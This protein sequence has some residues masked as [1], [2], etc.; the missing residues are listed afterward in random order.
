MTAELSAG[1]IFARLQQLVQG[2]SAAMLAKLP[3]L[4]DAQTQTKVLTQ[5]E[6]GR[7]HLCFVL[8]MK[9]AHFGE[10]HFTMFQLGLFDIDKVPSESNV[11]WAAY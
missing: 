1:E 9:V 7:A 5:F 8:T 10:G 2:S 3:P 6:A 4:T 11:L